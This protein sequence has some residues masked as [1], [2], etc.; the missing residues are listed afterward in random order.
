LDEHV[1]RV[2]LEH[3][4]VESRDRFFFQHPD[5][6]RLGQPGN[7]VEGLGLGAASAAP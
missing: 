6:R 4:G 3:L 5:G 2:G 7:L 1:G